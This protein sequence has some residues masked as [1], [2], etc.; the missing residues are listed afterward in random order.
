[1][2]A[3]AAKRSTF[4]QSCIAFLKKYNFDGLDMDW[5]YPAERG[6]K[7]IDKVRTTRPSGAESPST[8]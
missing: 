8:R 3:D 1:M 4:I 2:A 6:G 5:E 7:P